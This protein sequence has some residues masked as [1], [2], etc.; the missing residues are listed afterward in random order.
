MRLLA[1]LFLA[2]SYAL[3]VLSQT[4][5]VLSPGDYYV[6]APSGLNVRADPSPSAAKLGKLDYGARVK[7]DYCAYELIQVGKLEG[8]WASVSF[9]ETAGFVFSAYL[10]SIPAPPAHV[11]AEACQLAGEVGAAI[12]LDD[13]L[14]SHWPQAGAG[15][16]ETLYSFGNPV[17]EEKFRSLARQE[18][19][20]DLTVWYYSNYEEGRTT[21]TF[22]GD[23]F[24]AYAWLEARLRSCPSALHL[25]EDAHF[26]RNSADKVTQIE[27]GDGGWGFS[28]V[29]LDDFRVQLGL[30]WGV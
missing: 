24:Q 13:Y 15:M 12:L 5:H 16:A 7:V 10:S 11:S 1:L 8:W 27:S 22:R 6:T 17:D 18:L 9:G 20:P 26:L 3:P 30:G 25:L 2:C 29:R 21:L 28:I 14:K 19:S 23:V 4:P